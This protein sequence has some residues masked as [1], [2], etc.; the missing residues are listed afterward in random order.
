[1][2][3]TLN[4]YRAMSSFPWPGTA[5]TY[6][7]AVWAR[8]SDRGAGPI[9]D[10]APA[11]HIAG[12]LSDRPPEEPQRLP[13]Q[14]GWF[15]GVH[16]AR[17]LALVMTVDAPAYRELQRANSPYLRPYVTGDDI[18]SRPPDVIPRWC[19]DCGDDTLDQ[20]E[21]N[22]KVTHEF[23]LRH[24]LPTRTPAKLRSYKGLADRW[25]QFWNTRAPNFRKLRESSVCLAIPNVAKHVVCVERDA[26]NTYTN[27]VYLHKV[28]GSLCAVIHSSVFQDWVEAWSGT[29]GAGVRVKLTRAVRTFPLPYRACQPKSSW[30]TE[31]SA[32]CREQR[33][34]YT[35]L[36]NRICD[37]GNRERRIE[38]LRSA[39]ADADSA[40]LSAYGWSDL[41]I[42][43]DFVRTRFG[44]RFRLASELRA[45]VMSRLLELNRRQAP[46][47]CA[48]A[49]ERRSTTTPSLFDKR[50]D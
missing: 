37:P 48:P 8:R 35:D 2:S 39:L 32:W 10:G 20:V 43:H 25:W 6:A 23:L 38:M 18:T 29:M 40:A 30:P 31:A 36:F 34:G 17:G 5:T 27:Q 26:A 14:D 50:Y 49:S 3:E 9:L 7:I 28:T 15:E 11:V 16:N 42:R 12:D 47:T 1:V 13:N 46:A 41:V 45:E 19:V 22:C 4:L 24:V 44:I 21:S 33:A